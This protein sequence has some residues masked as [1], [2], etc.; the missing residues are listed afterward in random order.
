MK[1]QEIGD[2]KSYIIMYGHLPSYF[3]T[4][5]RSQGAQ[6]TECGNNWREKPPQRPAKSN[7]TR[8]I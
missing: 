6:R 4:I 7:Q 1:T 3:E 8:I 5:C 2:I